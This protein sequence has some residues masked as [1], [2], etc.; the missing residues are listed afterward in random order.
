[1]DLTLR[2]HELSEGTSDEEAVLMK[3]QSRVEAAK[4]LRHRR[5]DGEP[6]PAVPQG[7]ELDPR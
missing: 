4:R 5:G 1:M 3:Q 2:L 6:D 7:Y